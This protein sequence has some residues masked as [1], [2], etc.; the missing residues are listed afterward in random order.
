MIMVARANDYVLQRTLPINASF[1]WQTG[2]DSQM[3]IRTAHV[4]HVG[5]PRADADIVGA[6][7]EGHDCNRR[8]LR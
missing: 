1:A 5:W 7:Y 6:V 3:C 4:G 8:L 2:L